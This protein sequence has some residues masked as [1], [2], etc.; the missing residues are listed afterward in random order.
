M[1]NQALRSRLNEMEEALDAIRNGEVDAIMVYGNKGEQ[2][3]SVSSA[4]TPYRT[5]IEEMSEGAVT[6][7]K[8]G[9]IL[10]CNQR[11]AEIIQSPYEKVIGSSIKSFITPNDKSKLD[12]FLA[13][14]TYEKHD[15]LI[16]SLTNTLYLRLSIHLL[17]PYLQ[18]DNYILI[19]TDISDLKKREYE[20]IEIIGKLEN[21]IKALRALRIYNICD[22]LD[23]VGRKNKLETANNKLYKEILKLNRLVVKL[24]QKQKKDTIQ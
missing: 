4:E 17:P 6:L 12:S 24:K 18:G 15:V 20:L 10:Y 1:E 16:V 14:L 3:Y 11:F 19:A 9:T 7:T 5:F 2:V 13:Q 22:T 8:E 21:H 23:A